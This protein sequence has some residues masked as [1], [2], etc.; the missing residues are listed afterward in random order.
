MSRKLIWVYVGSK[1]GPLADLASLVIQHRDM[2][3]TLA[4]DRDRARLRRRIEARLRNEA[5]DR[6]L[7]EIAVKLGCKL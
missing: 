5:S 1:A 4:D 7:V 6:Q 2:P 3:V